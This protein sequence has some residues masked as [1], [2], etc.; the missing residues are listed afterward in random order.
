MLFSLRGRIEREPFWLVLVAV[1]L[2]CAIPMLLP[3]AGA[4]M[5]I[6]RLFCLLVAVWMTLAVSAKR[7]HDRGK[8]GLMTLIY[9]IPGV[10]AVWTI[11]E[12][13]FFQR[14][15]RPESLWG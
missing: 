6:F 11:I 7:W 13:G 10:G 5:L 2:A 8:S 1:A 14:D 15:C 4:R 3:N 12:L 9:L